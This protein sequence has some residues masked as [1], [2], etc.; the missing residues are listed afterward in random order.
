MHFAVF[1][2]PIVNVT[3]TTNK[4]PVIENELHELTCEVTGDVDEIHWMAKWAELKE[5]NTTV[6]HMN[7]KTVTFIPVDIDDAGTYHCTAV[8]VFGNMTSRAYNLVV[9]CKCHAK[10]FDNKYSQTIFFFK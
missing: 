2:D 4:I 9:N 6:F 10:H 7:N 8:N 1:S 3:I 5:D